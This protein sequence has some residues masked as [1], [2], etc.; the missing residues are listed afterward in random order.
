MSVEQPE[1]ADERERDVVRDAGVLE[2]LELRD[3]LV[4]GV[5]AWI[6]GFATTYVLANVA[7]VGEEYL[8]EASMTEQVAALFLSSLGAPLTFNGDTV[9]LVPW[10]LDVANSPTESAALVAAVA[11]PAVALYVAGSK[12]AEEYA[13][14][15]SAVT[16]LA[17]ASLAVGFGA[18]TLAAS[19]LFEI[20]EVSYAQRGL[21]VGGVLY[22]ATFGTLGAMSREGGLPGVNGGAKY[23]AGA[24][25]V[26]A[27]AWYSLAEVSRPLG[28]PGPVSDIVQGS[29]LL[30]W[31]NFFEAFVGMQMFG[32]ENAFY[33]SVLGQG[34]EVT[35]R[36]LPVVVL[37]AAG[38]LFVSKRT[39][40][41]TDAIEGAL[42]GGSVVVGYAL[43][44]AAVLV[45]LLAMWL[46]GPS[47]VH[48]TFLMGSLRH[49]LVVG[50]VVPFT[51]GALGGAIA[52]WNQ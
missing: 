52:A 48:A 16:V 6:A 41:P 11:L 40:T 28:R 42:E 27:F 36:W 47:D 24:F 4:Y 21:L 20:P 45:A 26:A 8:P 15:R 30:D 35:H 46:H 17:G 14:E 23:G 13:D 44:V 51:F 29:D 37:V 12:I 39:D 49:L 50:I 7:G 22:P 38:F 32:H 34:S 25:A 33:G 3:A 2:R 1:I 31:P 9:I 10:V 43:A 5:G 18:A 19:V